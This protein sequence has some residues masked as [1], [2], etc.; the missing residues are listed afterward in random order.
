M[1]GLFAV[2]AWFLL[3][4]QAFGQEAVS[5]KHPEQ[6]WNFLFTNISNRDNTYK[7][8]SFAKSNYAKTQYLGLSFYSLNKPEVKTTESLFS[9]EREIDSEIEGYSFK[10]TIKINGRQ[11]TV[12]KTN[13]YILG[14]DLRFLPE[15]LRVKKHSV[16]FKN[17]EGGF[18]W[19]GGTEINIGVVTQKNT[20]YFRQGNGDL[21][22]ISVPNIPTS[23]S[24]DWGPYLIFGAFGNISRLT[25]FIGVK[26]V[27]YSKDKRLSFASNIGIKF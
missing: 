10:D 18:F 14:L 15:K 4:S 9:I 16:L 6:E 3:F 24:F 1:K 12:E 25:A 8:F 21:N 11:E 26:K 2:L 27:Y 19:G 17:I 22:S 7:G 5:P 23:V 13:R 20:L